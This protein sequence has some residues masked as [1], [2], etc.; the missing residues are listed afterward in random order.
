M[1]LV[2]SPLFSPIFL[3]FG[4]VIAA[5]GSDS[6]TAT[7]PQEPEATI[8]AATS[9]TEAQETDV[10]VV[11]ST[12]TTTEA[13]AFTTT[14]DVPFFAL[15]GVDFEM[16]V[17]APNGEGPWP[18]V[19]AFH[20]LG[21]NRNATTV[22]VAKAAAAEGMLVFTPS[23]IDERSFPVT[24]EVFASWKPVANCAVAFAQQAADGYGGDRSTTVLHGFSAGVGPT[25]FASTEP[26]YEPIAGCKTDVAPTLPVGVVLGDGE[27][28]LHTETFDGAFAADA[29][30]MQANL[31]SLIDPSRWPSDLNARFFVWTAGDGINPRTTGDVSDESGWLALRDPSGSIRDDLEQLDQL[32]DGTLNYTDTGRLMELR[33]AEAG[34]DVTLDE[35]PGGHTTIDK[36]DEIV[37]YLQA[38]VG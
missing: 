8:A 35:Y 4:L 26:I 15:E 32:G 25:L 9:T 34:I 37:G 3:A 1:R 5:C 11:E 33:L 23:W 12:I 21:S 14:R 17:Y 24:P 18:V 30:A 29:E 16:D 13:P 28:L 38:A 31:A 27:F 6:G 20:G 2:L 7:G 19:V 10:S 22:E 36:L